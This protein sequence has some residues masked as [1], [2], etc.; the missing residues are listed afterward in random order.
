MATKPKSERL[1]DAVARTPIIRRTRGLA[2]LPLLLY[3]EGVTVADEE[4]ATAKLKKLIEL[5]RIYRV[6]PKDPDRWLHLLLRLADDYGLFRVE[7]ESERG[8]GRPRK[9]NARL[10]YL[11]IEEKVAQGMPIRTA[12]NELAGG[13]RKKARSMETRYHEE[14][15]RR[16]GKRQRRARD[17]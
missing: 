1:G 15:A 17:A 12:C 6:D 2:R 13:N 11:A 8:R 3:G 5:M 10:T 16:T 4:V 7:D 9:D 14:K